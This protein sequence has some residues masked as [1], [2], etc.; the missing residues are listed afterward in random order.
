MALMQFE[1]DDEHTDALE[2]VARSNKTSRR[3][4]LTDFVSDALD[5]VP[6]LMKMV[7]DRRLN[8]I[9]ME[10][11]ISIPEQKDSALLAPKARP[12]VVNKYLF[13]YRDKSLGVLEG[14]GETSGQ[15]LK[16]ALGRDSYM[17]Y[18]EYEKVFLPIERID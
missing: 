16:D 11:E 8:G 9:A 6:G 3:Q 13:R 4:Y 5:R 14:K 2:H 7:R 12:V 1:L 10:A 17:P 15:A 18:E